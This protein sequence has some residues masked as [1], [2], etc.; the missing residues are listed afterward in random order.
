MNQTYM[1]EKPI[2]PLLLSMA[3]P[4]I[5]SMLVNSLYNIID[6][7]FVA[8]INED[9]L[10]ALSLVFPVQNLI[11]SIGVG[12]GV[13]VNAVIAMSLGANNQKA[14]NDAASQ[15]LLCSVIHGALFML[16]G[17]PA[18]PAFLRLFTDSAAVLDY[19]LC[20]STIV[21]SFSVIITVEITFEKIFQSVGRMTASMLSLLTGCIVNIILDPLMIFGIG[22]FPE[23]GMKGAAWATNIGQLSTLVIYLAIWTFNPP[24]LKLSLPAMKPTKKICSQLYL[25]GIPATLNMALPS[26]LVSAL[27]SILSVYSQ[28]YVLTLGIYY[29]LQ[30]FLYL[31][32]NGAI[33]GMRP[34]LGY[35]A[36]AKEYM[37]VRKIYKTTAVIIVLV[38]SLGM[39]LCLTIPGK[40]MGMFTENPATIQTG[41]PALRTICFGFV[42]SS[43]SVVSA[44]A[45]EALGKGPKSLII[46][47]L[48]YVFFI[49][50]AAFL[51]CRVFGADTIWNAFWI[52]EAAAALIAFTIYR[53]NIDSMEKKEKI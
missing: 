31:P 30:T 18:M 5:L 52:T 11:C 14:A 21:L 37:R 12:F 17:I 44:G 35:N 50:P 9:A 42:V 39:I 15:G 7:I 43:L 20:Y 22:P 19:G 51:L 23:M 41:I 49:I 26:L 25:T 13:G 33:Q 40:L 47:C 24:N 3:I 6:S 8:K 36:G 2:L 34:L 53:K 46:S 48:R 32:A 45:L 16:F 10:T 29:K 28:T 4:M 27:N 38:M 1:K